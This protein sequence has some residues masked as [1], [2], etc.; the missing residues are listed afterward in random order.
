MKSQKI[1]TLI[2]TDPEA[3]VATVTAVHNVPETETEAE[4][5]AEGEISWRQLLKLN[6]EYVGMKWEAVH[7]EIGGQLPFVV[8]VK[9]GY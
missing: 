5:T 2:F 8:L 3:V 4:E 1:K 6:F 7:W 9:G